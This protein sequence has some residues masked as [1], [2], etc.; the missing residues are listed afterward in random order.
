MTTLLQVVKLFP[1]LCIALAP[2]SCAVTACT[3]LGRSL[4]SP[5][6]S[7]REIK[8]CNPS[9]YSGNYWIRGTNV[10][11]GIVTHR[12]YCDMHRERCGI[13]GGWTRV[14]DL[15][16]TSYR[17]TCPIGLQLKTSPRMCIKPVQR[18]GCSSVYYH[19]YGMSYTRVCGRATGFACAT[20]DS[21]KKLNTIGFEGAYVD[22]VSISH[23]QQD[24]SLSRKHIWTFMV[25]AHSKHCQVKLTSFM[26][27]D[28]FCETI[29]LYHGTQ[30]SHR[31]L[32]DGLDCHWPQNCASS[33][34]PWFCRTLP[35]PTTDDIEVR[36]CRNEDRSNEDVGLEQLELYL[37]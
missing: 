34:Q 5:A 20:V 3:A 29:P 35:L 18:G 14:A 22:G 32:W 12:R 17:S 7:C 4:S 11:G 27:S 37:F 1:L 10:Y 33:G 31:R 6:S 24:D 16:M 15:D 25:E 21:G 8:E 9:A 2:P 26:Q 36:V 30:C 23:R 13:K 28:F 19:T